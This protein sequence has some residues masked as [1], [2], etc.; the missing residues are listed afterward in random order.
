MKRLRVQERAG[1]YIQERYPV[2]LTQNINPSQSSLTGFT[3]IELILVLVIIGFLT[4]L[5][6]P[7]IT[8]TT[9][10]RLK[11]TTKRIAAALRFA[12][13]QAVISGSNY[14]ATFDLEKGE[15]TVECLAEDNS[16]GDKL[17]EKEEWEE[18]ADDENDH[19]APEPGEVNPLDVPGGDLVVGLMVRLQV[20]VVL[21]D[22]FGR[23]TGRHA[24]Q[25]HSSS[26]SA[27]SGV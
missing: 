18:D 7:A 6:A 24:H 20:V 17:D 22:R 26:S 5:V 27:H 8:S 11:T 25:L 1:A 21:L 3:L 4:S 15:V 2:K 9:G 10:L 16:F 13:S 19:E 14:R 23:I 12:R